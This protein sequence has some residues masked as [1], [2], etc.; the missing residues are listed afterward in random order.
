[1]AR[2]I[3]LKNYFAS[4]DAALTD[5][6]H[7]AETLIGYWL[8]WLVAQSHELP[9]VMRFDIMAKR[10]GPGKA[11]IHTGELT[12]LGGCFLGWQAGLGPSLVLPQPSV[13]HWP[14]SW[15]M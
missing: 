4:D 12:E 9:V 5:A 1:M 3:C 8:Q 15:A 7:Q 2:R 14:L 10:I 13:S 6:E 11:V